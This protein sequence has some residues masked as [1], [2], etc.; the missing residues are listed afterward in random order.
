[1]S[2]PTTRRYDFDVPDRSE[3][4]D[5][6]EVFSTPVE[7]EV[8]HLE[9]GDLIDLEGDPHADP[10]SDNI[11]FEFEFACVYQIEHETPGC[12]RV[13]LVEGGSFG[14]PHDHKVTHAGVDHAQRRPA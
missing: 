13:D 11:T 9:P 1:M 14:F 7:V 2:D 10:D 12:V 8:R 5:G 3:L 4:D 6:V